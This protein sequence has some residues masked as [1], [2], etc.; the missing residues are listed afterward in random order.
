MR[1]I[2]SLGLLAAASASAQTVNTQVTGLTLT[3]GLS[4]VTDAGAVTS[5]SNTANLATGIGYLTDNSVL[6]QVWNFGLN[7]TGLTFQGAFGGTISSQAD[8][9]YFVGA[10]Q[11]TGGTEPASPRNGA[12]NLQLELTTGL[13]TARSYSDINYILT[14]QEITNSLGVYFTGPGFVANPYPP[15]TNRFFVTYLKVPF[16][17]FGATYDQVVGVRVS[18]VSANWP[19]IGYVGVGY[20]G[21]AVPEPSTYGL[22]LGG[23]ALAGAALRRRQRAK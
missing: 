18:N 5:T 4:S 2:A 17:D 15:G 22:I 14:S 10:A 6:T 21:T 13:T 23:L 8:A 12:F 9:I 3:N 20:G 19:D 1:F 11:S 7:T 16:S